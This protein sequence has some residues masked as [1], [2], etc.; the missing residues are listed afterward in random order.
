MNYSDW[1]PLY[2]F[3]L[4]R[5]NFSE[6]SDIK[7]AVW[8]SAVLSDFFK[9]NPEFKNN[10]SAMFSL[11]NKIAG[12][13]IVI[14]GNAPTLEIEYRLLQ[15]NK[16]ADGSEIYIA[17]DGA[18]SVLLKNKKVPDIIVTDLDGKHPNDAIKEIEAVDKGALLL[19]HAHGD[20]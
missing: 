7:T 16:N 4:D 3:I 6:A 13:N 19:I 15:E 5:F 14:C 8:F 18:A 11:K 10:E 2:R 20:N 1:E 12:K 9:N 17:A